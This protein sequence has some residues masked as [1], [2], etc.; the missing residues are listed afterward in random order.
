[1]L[2]ENYLQKIMKGPALIKTGSDRNVVVL[3]VLINL[4]MFLL[5]I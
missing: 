3:H 5:E 4:L 2:N 1:M